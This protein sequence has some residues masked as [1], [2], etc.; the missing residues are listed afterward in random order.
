VKRAALIIL[1]AC[2]FS[3]VAAAGCS[4]HF[5]NFPQ[6]S[7]KDAQTLIDDQ[8]V[9]RLRVG[10]PNVRVSA[11]SCPA[12][13]DLSDHHVGHCVIRVAQLAYPVKV[14]FDSTTGQLRVLGTGSVFMMNTVEN[15]TQTTLKQYVAGAT[16][17][18][19][20]GQ[21]RVR[22]YAIGEQF[23]CVLGGR[24]SGVRVWLKNMNAKAMLFVFRPKQIPETPEQLAWDRAAAKHKRGEQTF[25]PGSL[26]EGEIRSAEREDQDLRETA[27]TNSGHLALTGVTCPQTIDVS[28]IRHGRCLEY[29]SG[30][31]LRVDIWIDK[32]GSWNEISLDNAYYLP[33]ITRYAVE[34]YRKL[35]L[36]GGFIRN[37]RVN[38]GAGRLIIVTPPAT[39]KCSIKTGDEDWRPMHIQFR[40]GGSFEFYIP[41]RNSD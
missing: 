25:V 30:K 10:L 18:V 17:P 38:C 13:M 26:V 40:R 21:P 24:Y 9:T 31:P 7:G 1:T 39:Q 33:D 6:V 36:A 5:G 14:W 11:S 41:A 8:I 12:T 29:I 27:K 34:Y 35:L 23:S 19:N 16:I 28:G 22:L 2:C 37:I 15:Y 32:T 4:V 20:C 3:S